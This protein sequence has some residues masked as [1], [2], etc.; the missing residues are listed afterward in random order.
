MPRAAPVTS[1]TLPSSRPL[2]RAPRLSRRTTRRARTARGLRVTRAA[3]AASSRLRRSA[4][5]SSSTSQLSV[6]VSTSIVIK[7]P[8]RTSAIGP[9]RAA[10][11]ET[12]PTIK[13]AR[14]AAEA[15]VGDED[16]RFAE[17]APDDRRG[18]RQHLGHPRCAGRALVADDDDVARL[19]RAAV[20]RR[21]ARLLRVEGARRPTVDRVLVARE[22]DD[23]ALGSE[24]PEEHAQRAAWLERRA[25][26]RDHLAVGLGRAGGVLGSVLPS[27]VGASASDA[28]EAA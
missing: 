23:R 18:D 7:S 22:L 4:S 8:S 27:T 14:C 19:N 20:D 9:P 12:W 16:D 6:R 28:G 21:L 25:G 5:S 1:A 10:S 11:G 13:P 17:P 26:D 15:A 24:V 3:R 2:I